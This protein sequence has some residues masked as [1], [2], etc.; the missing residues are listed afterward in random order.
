[1][2]SKNWTQFYTDLGKLLD[3]VEKNTTGDWTPFFA[4][5]SAL[6]DDMDPADPP[7]LVHSVAN[8]K[9]AIPTQAQPTARDWSGFFTALVTFMQNILPLILP[10]FKPTA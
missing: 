5:L 3:L 7:Q 9:A 10:L 4:L 2:P 6:L 8:L 1:M